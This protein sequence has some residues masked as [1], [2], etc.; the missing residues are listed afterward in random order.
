MSR[1]KRKLDH[2]QYALENGQSRGNGLE[3]INFVHQS[4][5][6]LSV[7]QIDLSS[8]IGGLRISSPIFIN[9][10]TGGGGEVTKKINRSFSEVAKHCNIPMAVGS[11]MAAIK[12]SVERETYKVV[13]ET[14]P[15]GIIFANLGSEATIENAKEAIDMIEANGIQIHLNVVQELVMPEGD[16]NFNN[17]LKRIESIVKHT[18]IPV[19]I[20]EVGF[21]ISKETAK[22]L[23]DVGI[24]G[25]D[26]GGFGG[27]NFSE[28]ENKR[29][30]R[31]LA[32]FNDW[33]ISTASSIAEVKS[34][35]KQHSIIGSG[36]IQ[37]ALDVAKA[38]G[39]GASVA[40]FAGHF[41]K[42]VIQQGED[43]LKEEV[44]SILTDLRILMTALGTK[45]IREL[46]KAPIVISGS[47]FHWLQQ[48]GID[49]TIYSQR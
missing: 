46:Q 1:A 16:R 8:M 23:I 15:S 31:V 18:N 27:T 12:D 9:A 10:M 4:I 22:Q 37:N 19:L 48:R 45:N 26:V 20:K 36:G 5:P 6:N 2:I 11:Q 41:L 7:D 29:R 3:D 38:I 33:G 34:V 42:I 30:D 24:S 35:V 44:V 49:T 17:V 13:R 47:T 28:I 39:L 43:A 21:G 32:Y 25:I 14:N 40:A